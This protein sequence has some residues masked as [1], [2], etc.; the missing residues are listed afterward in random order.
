[1]TEPSHERIAELLALLPPAPPGWVQAASEL[2]RARELMDGIVARAAADA[3]YRQQ[4]LEDLEA[5]LAQGGVEPA[6]PLVAELRHRL[7]VESG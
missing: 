7:E 4:V 5:A 1:M 3:G 6:A 2:P